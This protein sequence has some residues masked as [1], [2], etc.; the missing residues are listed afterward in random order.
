M[1]KQIKVKE[2]MIEKV[3]SIGKDK[4]V[5]EAGELMKQEDVGSLIV[6]EDENVVGILTGTDLVKKVISKNL[7]PEKLKVE[8]VMSRDIYTIN[9]DDNLAD[10]TM[11]IL[12]KDVKRLPVVK[13]D[14]LVGILSY[15]DILKISPDLID[16]LL[17]RVEEEEFEERFGPF[18]EESMEEGNLC[19][20]CGNY[21]EDLEK[22]N[23]RWT[24]EECREESGFT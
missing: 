14:T 11:K 22:T 6:T 1:P 9:P 23:G 3:V 13:D 4:S 17:R 18:E 5:K 20:V 16:F 24:C 19:E 10:A 15:K 2:A 8:E 21:S 12:K 7:K